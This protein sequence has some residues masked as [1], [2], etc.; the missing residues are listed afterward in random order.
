MLKSKVHWPAFPELSLAD[1]EMWLVQNMYTFELRL[2]IVHLKNIV[3]IA[4]WFVC[5]TL[6]P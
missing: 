1:D 2:L 5:V 6:K 4:G 3:D